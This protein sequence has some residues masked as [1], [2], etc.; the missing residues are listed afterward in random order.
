MPQEVRALLSATKD[1]RLEAL[2]ILGLSTGMRGGELLGLE[3]KHINLEAGTLDVK[4]TTT[5]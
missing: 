4:Q 3:C 1:D 5:I 2:Y